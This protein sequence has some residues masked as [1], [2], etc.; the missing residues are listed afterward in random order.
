[1][2]YNKTRCNEAIEAGAG[3]FFFYSADLFLARSAAEKAL[4]ALARTSDDEITTLDGPAPAVESLVMAAGTI[5]FFGTRRVVYL[6]GMQPSAYGEKDFGELCDLLTSAEN[7][8]F[9]LYS[10]FPMER[11]KLKLGKLGKKLVAVCEK[12]GYAAQLEHPGPQQMR[13]ILRQRAGQLNTTLSENA[14]AAIL[15]RCG[16]DLFLLENEVDKLAAASGYTEI[17]PA[18]VVEMGTRDLEADV[19]DMVRCV[20]SKNAARACEILGVLLRLKTDPPSIAAALASSFVDMYRMKAAQAAKIDYMQVHKDFGY[21][22]KPA[23]LQ[24]SGRTAARYTSAQLAACLDILAELD[25]DLKG[26][27]PIEADVLLQTALCRLA[28]A[29]GVR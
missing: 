16:Q 21:T 8:V 17:T 10:V 19:F 3:V 14:A 23:R 18:L 28:A 12:A 9:V 15:E 20:T 6:P 1:M 29:G 27:C 24:I 25:E 26:G 7:S 4:A 2:L 13:A 11:D 22:G 5:S